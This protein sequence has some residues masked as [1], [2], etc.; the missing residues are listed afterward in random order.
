M[1]GSEM[2]TYPLR[3]AGS[4]FRVLKGSKEEIQVER[5]RYEGLVIYEVTSDELE[6]LK[7]ET[8]RISEDLS[9]LIFGASVALS[10]LVTILTVD[11]LPERTFNIFLIFCVLG[12]LVALYCGIRWFRGRRSFE[13]TITRI[14]RRVGPLGQEGKEIGPADPTGIPQEVKSEPAR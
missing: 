5:H 1:N 8:L 13:R 12:F 6:S 7:V 4:I 11:N 9:F 3:V 2:L 10:F 14:E